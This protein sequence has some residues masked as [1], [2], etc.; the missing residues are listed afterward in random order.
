MRKLLKLLRKLL[1]Q[2]VTVA[3]LTQS[4]SD[5]MHQLSQEM[6]DSS[7]AKIA[8]AMQLHKDAEQ[9]LLESNR[10]MMVAARIGDILR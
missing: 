6:Q 1:G 9:D 2:K 10:A 8:A 7:N 3:S 5:V 4:F